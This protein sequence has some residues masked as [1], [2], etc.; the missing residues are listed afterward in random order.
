MYSNEKANKELKSIISQFK[1][2]YRIACDTSRNAYMKTLS[3]GAQIPREGFIYGDNFKAE[4]ESM[5]SG[6]RD[7]VREIIGKNLSELREK[8][9]EA[10]STEA[11]NSITLLNMRKD[12][13]ENEIENLLS[14]Y[15]DNHQARNTIVSIARNHGIYNFGDDET[16]ER[17]ADLE[18]LESNLTKSLSASTAN[19]GLF[20]MMELDIDDVFPVEE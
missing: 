7:K 6:Y 20:A 3:A 11:V 8:M 14:R 17:I 1:D 15:G 19:D 5:S 18:S 9:T 16:T 10:P 12:V 2:S 4:F 13:T